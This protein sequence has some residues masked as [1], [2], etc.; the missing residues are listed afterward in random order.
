MVMRMPTE[1]EALELAGRDMKTVYGTNRSP[2]GEDL[3]VHEFT[4]PALLYCT[5]CGHPQVSRA[6]GSTQ[7]E[8]EQAEKERYL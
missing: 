4:P 6:H 1:G 5:L 7:E 8:I 2:A 3:P